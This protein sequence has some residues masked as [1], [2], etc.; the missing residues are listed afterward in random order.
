MSIAEEIKDRL[1]IVDVVSAYVPLRKAGRVYKALCPFHQEKTPSFVV[2]PE[3]GTWRCFGACGTGGDLFAFVMKRENLDFREALELLAPK[4]GVSLAPPDQETSERDQYLDK[5]RE[6]NQTAALYFHSQLGQSP[7]G[8]AARE[9]LDKRGLDSA[10]IDKFQL[11][12]APDSWDGLMNYLRDPGR[13]YELD[14]ILAAGLVIEKEYEDTGRVRH[15]DRFR[16][17]VMVPIRDIRGQVIGFGARALTSDQQPKYLNTSQTPLFDKSSIL[18]GLDAARQA[19]RAKGKAI[20]VEGYMDVLACHQ[21]GEGNVVASMGT[22]L[23]EQQLR[24][25]RRYTDTIVLALDADT[26]GQA[27]TLRGISQA[28]ESLDREWVP[29]L[30]PRGMLR[31]EARLAADLRIMTLPEGQDP[32]DVVR[33]NPDLWRSLVEAAQPVVDFYFDL[34][35]QTEDL[36]TAQGKSAAVDELAPLILEVSNEI[37]RAHYAQQ[38]ARLV[39]TDERTIERELLRRASPKRAVTQ[40]LPPD[41]DTPPP[42]EADPDLPAPARTPA[43]KPRA[44]GNSHAVHLL[45]LLVS[46]SNIFPH[47][48]SELVELG[49]GS[50]DEDDFNRS[51]ERAVCAALLAGNLDDADDWDSSD[52]DLARYAEQLRAYGQRWPQL[53]QQQLLKDLVDTVLRL[54]IDNL[55]V[56]TRALPALAQDAESEGNQDD[57]MAYRQMQ[58]ELSQHRRSLEQTLNVRTYAGRRK[59]APSL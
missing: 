37:Q 43:R 50:L 40:Q 49:V 1:D 15:Y 2:F 7:A 21:F 28:R 10:T 27:A 18:F 11:G 41:I 13:G 39:Q 52:P 51:E 46:Q 12:Y 5:L 22:A 29:S 4:A 32:D 26:A 8:A 48:Q 38:L 59:L 24:Q 58:G 54:R 23:T 16:Q 47:L 25:L 35:R 34:V 45:A 31:F 30:D 56:R 20:I 36:S 44:L 53:S 6:I 17:R 33:S 3:S 14:D 55:E 42:I 19:I 57:A 9:Y